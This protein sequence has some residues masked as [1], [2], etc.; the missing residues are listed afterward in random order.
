MS[1]EPEVPPTNH[2]FVHVMI[3]TPTGNVTFSSERLAPEEAARQLDVLRNSI[4]QSTAANL[5]WFAYNGGGIVAAWSTS[6]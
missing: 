6:L 4:Y 1:D 3:L 2:S 5:P